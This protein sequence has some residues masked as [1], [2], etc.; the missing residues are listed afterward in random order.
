M[1]VSSVS[2]RVSGIILVL[3]SLTL[4]III[5]SLLYCNICS[6]N[7]PE[8]VL[9]LY[10]YEQLFLFGPELLSSRFFFANSLNCVKTAYDQYNSFSTLHLAKKNAWRLL[11]P[12]VFPLQIGYGMNDVIPIPSPVQHKYPILKFFKHIL[13]ANKLLH[14]RKFRLSFPNGHL[15]AWKC[16]Y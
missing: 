14:L 16:T 13:T 11:E 8:T 5:N 10:L 3:S 15:N 7:E 4:I 9:G 6:V 12:T 2:E 1:D